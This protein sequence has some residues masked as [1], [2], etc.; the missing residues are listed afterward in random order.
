MWTAIYEDGSRLTQFEEN[1]EEHLFNEIDQDKLSLFEVKLK[2]HIFGVSLYE[3]A[4]R[5]DDVYFNFEGFKKEDKFK[6]IY[7]RR[8]RKTLGV[9]T[10]TTHHCLGWQLEGGEDK[11]NQKR[12]LKV[13][14]ESLKITFEIK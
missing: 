8:V 5:I 4:F 14:E 7:F 11:S 10:N 6:L 3:G 1:G 9:G 13:L 2:D 12:I